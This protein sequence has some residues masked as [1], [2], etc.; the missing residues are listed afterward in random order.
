M[1]I[2]GTHFFT[3]QLLAGLLLSCNKT[4]S[5]IKKSQLEHL[6]VKIFKRCLVLQAFFRK[7]LKTKKHFRNDYQSLI[8]SFNSFKHL[9]KSIQ[10]DRLCFLNNHTFDAIWK[11]GLIQSNVTLKHSSEAF[12]SQHKQI[13][14]LPVLMWCHSLYLD[15]N[16]N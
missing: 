16:T 2:T 1:K 4:N 5:E 10:N 7:T 8:Q 14:L 12:L 13:S 9:H 6:R 11:Y 15:S 3:Q